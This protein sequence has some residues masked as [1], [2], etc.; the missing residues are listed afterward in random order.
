MTGSP[1]GR[2]E[3]IRTDPDLELARARLTNPSARKNARE[4]R[5]ASRGSPRL[6]GLLPTLRWI[7][8]RWFESSSLP[9][10]RV[11]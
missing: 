6:A 1:L 9:I 2:H 3:K 5:N 4:P 11:R 7:R 10:S 8:N